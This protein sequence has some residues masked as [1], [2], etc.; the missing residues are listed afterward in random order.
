MF[1][2]ATRTRARCRVTS[3]VSSEVVRIG[4]GRKNEVLSAF[5]AQTRAHHKRQGRASV[6]AYHHQV[7]A[8]KPFLVLWHALSTQ[9]HYLL[10]A[11]RRRNLE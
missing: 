9:P 5:Q 11:C 6:E 1:P 3:V 2:Y 10:M 7:D 8:Y 4:D